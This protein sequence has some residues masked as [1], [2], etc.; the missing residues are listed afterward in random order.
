MAAVTQRQVHEHGPNMTTQQISARRRL[1]YTYNNTGALRNGGPG[2]GAGRTASWFFVG[3]TAVLLLLIA[4]TVRWAERDNGTISKLGGLRNRRNK[5]GAGDMWMGQMRDGTVRKDVERTHDGEPDRRET[6]EFSVQKDATGGDSVA[7][8]VPSAAGIG[9][10]IERGRDN[11]DGLID[12]RGRI[13]LPVGKGCDIVRLERPNAPT[14]AP[15]NAER[16]RRGGINQQQEEEEEEEEDGIRVAI[17]VRHGLGNRLRSLSTAMVLAQ[18]LTNF[19]PDVRTTLI[20]VWERD[21]H[22]QASFFDLFRR[23]V[24][25][26]ESPF[27]FN[28]VV[29]DTF[30]ANEYESF[31]FY[32]YSE[33]PSHGVDVR[34]ILGGTN[35]LIESSYPI[36]TKYDKN[37]DFTISKQVGTRVHEAAP[38]H[39]ACD[40]RGRSLSLRRFVASTLNRRQKWV[41][42]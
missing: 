12:E 20:V 31:D 37:A 16:A 15:S 8:T 28:L 2:T 23:D 34:R 36:Q 35:A 27:A 32:D 5:V 7:V 6:N 42:T 29:R 33:C 4:S 1:G 39:G 10:D 13:R 40:V 17:R 25:A 38:A 21:V 24:S 22:C 14:A 11:E 19:K 3:A 9:R 41:E 18:K 26:E 30:D